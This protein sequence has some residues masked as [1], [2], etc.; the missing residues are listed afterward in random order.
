VT[1][2]FRPVQTLAEMSRTYSDRIR[3]YCEAHGIEIPAGFH[4]HPASPYAAID[5]GRTPP[6]LVATTWFKQADLLYY[7]ERHPHPESLRLVDFRE[8]AEFRYAGRGRLERGA[9]LDPAAAG[10]PLSD[11][12]RALVERQFPPG[13]REAAARM[14]LEHCGNN[15]PYL[16][17]GDATSLER[18]RF[19][20]LRIAAGNLE[21]LVQAI[22][23]ARTDWR[24]LLVEADFANDTG[25]HRAWFERCV[26]ASP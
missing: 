19:A 4:R 14:L 11:D 24:D 7:V 3:R 15:L 1:A 5:T 12:T 2:G 26:A 13:D 25:A 10:P 6:K 8:G 22:A 23:L 16:E 21:R 9:L 18:F 17:N 20:A